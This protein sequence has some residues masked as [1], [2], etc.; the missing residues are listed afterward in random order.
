MLLPVFPIVAPVA[1]VGLA[2]L[3]AAIVLTVAM[4]SWLVSQ[5]N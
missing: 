3:L 5:F 4:S 1:D 2:A